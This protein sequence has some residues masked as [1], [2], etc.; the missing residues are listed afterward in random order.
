MAR[1]AAADDNGTQDLSADYN[2]EGQEQT[3]RDGGDSRV[4]M[5]A[6]VAEDGGSRQQW[7]RQTTT[8][9]DNNGTQDWVAD[10]N[11]E[12]QEQAA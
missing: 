7:Q 6:A 5:M 11:G 12:G 2:G 4:V 10:Y 3:A 1:A 9:V 8:A